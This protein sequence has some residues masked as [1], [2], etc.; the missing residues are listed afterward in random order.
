MLLIG[1]V[2]EIIC[3][4]IAGLAGHFM[5]APDG[6]P[7]DQI[8]KRNIQG[9]QLLVAFAILQIMFFA[10]FCGSLGGRVAHAPV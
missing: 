1:C 2:G 6:T 9:G 3:A 4:V 5:L 10:C 8:T 7:A